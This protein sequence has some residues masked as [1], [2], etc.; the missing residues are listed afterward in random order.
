MSRQTL[1]RGSK[2]QK[3]QAALEEALTSFEKLMLQEEDLKDE[4]DYKLIQE[5]VMLAFPLYGCF[6]LF[7]L[8]LCCSAHLLQQQ[9]GL[10]IVL[11]NF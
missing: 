2:H 1:P 11:A 4:Q 7:C 10:R 5:Q 3:K 9:V 8:L 6:V